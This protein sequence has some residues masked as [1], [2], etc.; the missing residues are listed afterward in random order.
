MKVEQ[1][2]MAYG[3]EQD[4]LRAILPPGFVSLRPILRIHAEIRDDR[5][6]Y[7]E[8]HTAVEH[9]NNRGWLNIG[10]W[11]DV[12]YQKIEKTAFFHTDFLDIT[13]TRV[14]IQGSCPA[15]KDHNGCYFL[16]P[17]MICRK[18]EKITVSKEFC[19]CEFRWKFTDADAH[20]VS[21]GKTLP[22]Y[23]TEIRT[24][25][26]KEAWTAE[27]AAKIPC[28]QVLGAYV[29]CFDRELPFDEQIGFRPKAR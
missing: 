28:Q 24:V 5:Q 20:G 2:V 17:P 9:D 26:P 29:V 15:E 27:N 23:P 7:L 19:D 8:F 3:V 6:G 12:S 18:P 25:Y 22:A 4:R 14:G 21:V 11:H 13:F 1:Y 10:F 16:G